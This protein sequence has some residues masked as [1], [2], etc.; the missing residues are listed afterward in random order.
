MTNQS[1]SIIQNND[2]FSVPE[3]DGGSVIKGRM[4]KFNDGQYLIDKTESLPAE[5]KLV[6]VAVITAWVHWADGKPA[7]HLVTHP[8]E[9][10]P[11]REDLADLDQSKWPLGLNG[12]PNDPW[13]DTRYLHLIDPLT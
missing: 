5:T 3:K 13:K 2:G 4:I 1:I 7:E 9:M 11:E 8:G 12:E 10:H 6:A